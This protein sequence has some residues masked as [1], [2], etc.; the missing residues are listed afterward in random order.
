MP[1]RESVRRSDAPIVERQ[2]LRGNECAVVTVGKGV[3]AQRTQQ[4]REGIHASLQIKQ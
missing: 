3:H 2:G 1:V 4:N